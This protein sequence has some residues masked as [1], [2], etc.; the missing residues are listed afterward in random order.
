MITRKELEF[1]NGKIY[2]ELGGMYNDIQSYVSKYKFTEKHNLE[3]GYFINENGVRCV[4][5]KNQYKTIPQKEK[6]FVGREAS[7][8]ISWN[9][10]PVF[11]PSDDEYYD[12][13]NNIVCHNV[14]ENRLVFDYETGKLKE[15]FNYT[16]EEEFEPSI[17]L[18]AKDAVNKF[19]EYM[20]KEYR[21]KMPYTNANG[22]F[23]YEHKKPK[24]YE[25]V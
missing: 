11:V 20:K 12:E 19:I 17:G 6:E 25:N 16:D 1:L 24:N 21:N 8:H 3:D 2:S 18:S 23:L 22:F 9:K 14:C 15:S 10:Q 5:Y 7:I 4:I 13:F